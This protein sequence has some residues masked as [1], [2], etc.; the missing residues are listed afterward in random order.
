MK[1][2]LL[3]NPALFAVVRVLALP[4]AWLTRKRLE[5]ITTPTGCR[6]WAR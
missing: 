2:W 1:S 4:H 5:A 3:W 6:A